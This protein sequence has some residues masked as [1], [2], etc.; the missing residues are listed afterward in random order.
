MVT[1]GKGRAGRPIN[2]SFGT[3]ISDRC[4]HPQRSIKVSFDTLISGF[5]DHQQRTKKQRYKMI[6]LFCRI[7]ILTWRAFPP[8]FTKVKLSFDNLISGPCGHQQDQ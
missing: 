4:D 1:K 2:V 8:L 6:T 7:Q 5:C 3:L